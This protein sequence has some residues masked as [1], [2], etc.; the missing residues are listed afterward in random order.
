MDLGVAG[1]EMDRR[2]N[3][4]VTYDRPTVVEAA[5]TLTRRVERIT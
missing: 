2:F 3:Y 1:P 4:A 5:H